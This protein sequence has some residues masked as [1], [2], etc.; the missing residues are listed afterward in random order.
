MSSRH[1]QET[2]AHFHYT[3]VK[4]MVKWLEPVHDALPCAVK[5]GVLIKN[6]VLGRGKHVT[7]RQHAHMDTSC[8][9]KSYYVCA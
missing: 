9:I 4:I 6:G 8:P 2:P 1:L 5:N 7:P 3:D